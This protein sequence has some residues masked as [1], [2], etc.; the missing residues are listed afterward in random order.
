MRQLNGMATSVTLSSG[1]VMMVTVIAAPTAVRM[2]MEIVVVAM[3]APAQLVV[4]LAVGLQAVVVS[5]VAAAVSASHAASCS[6]DRRLVHEPVA[7]RQPLPPWLLCAPG[8][9]ERSSTLPI[10]PVW[11][12][13][14]FW[15]RFRLS[16]SPLVME[17]TVRH[18]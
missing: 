9:R 4:V 14:R 7:L 2:L 3:E 10:V 1:S 6:W 18:A 5:L 15:Y 12:S 17:L 11:S 8:S 13:A 16:T